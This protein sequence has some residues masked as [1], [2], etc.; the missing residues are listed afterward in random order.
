MKALFKY[1]DKSNKIT[2]E[3]TPLPPFVLSKWDGGQFRIM[4]RLSW[5]FKT[6]I[7]KILGNVTFFL[8]VE[9]F[10]Y[11]FFTFGALINF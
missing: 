11:L 7:I 6:G 2:T 8:A 9:L 5:K 10:D 4:R 1:E 3:L